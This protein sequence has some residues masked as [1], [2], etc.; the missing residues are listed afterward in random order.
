MSLYYYLYAFW[1]NKSYVVRKDYAV[2]TEEN[3]MFI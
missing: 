3:V 2:D 1:C